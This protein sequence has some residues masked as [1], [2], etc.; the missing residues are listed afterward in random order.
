M[1]LITPGQ[2]ARRAEF[3]HQIGQLTSAGLGLIRA[4]EQLQRSPPDRSYRPPLQRLLKRLAEGYS[5]SE[6]LRSMGPWLPEFDIALIQAGEQSGRLE[7]CFRLLADYYNDRAR[8][9]RQMIADLAYPLFLFHFAIFIF[10]FAQLFASGNWAVY[11]TKTLGV[12]LPIY[13][14]VAFII[15]AGQSKH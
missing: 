8:M 13:A 9:A 11:L 5:F 1:L 4:L 7:S 6:A 2:L 15:Y 12:L 10:P 14:V 3:Y